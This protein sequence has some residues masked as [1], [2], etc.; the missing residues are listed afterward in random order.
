[1]QPYTDLARLLHKLPSVTIASSSEDKGATAKRLLDML[2]PKR[3]R[4]HIF[5]SNQ[6]NARFV[7]ELGIIGFEAHYNFLYD[8]NGTILIKNK[9]VRCIRL[10]NVLEDVN[11]IELRVGGSELNALRG[12]QDVTMRCHV[13]WT[14]YVV[15]SQS[16]GIE[17]LMQAYNFRLF[18]LYN[19]VNTR[20][21]AVY[22]NNRFY[23]VEHD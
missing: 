19:Q 15:G 3:C 9:P 4:I 12:A 8:T 2:H 11:L 23:E 17:Q 18:N 1:M 14:Q 22:I 13:I 5:E 7:S 10:D 16:L 20:T 21:D 6:N